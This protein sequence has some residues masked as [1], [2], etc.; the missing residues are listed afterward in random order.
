MADENLEI[1]T[2]DA[3]AMARQ[4]VTRSGLLV[5]ISAAA[6]V[7]GSLKIAGELAVKDEGRRR[8]SYD[9]VR[10]RRQISKRKILER[11]DEPQHE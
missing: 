4:V 11:R 8:S 7:V 2:E 5:G 9:P 10:L 3:Y 6:A 1:S